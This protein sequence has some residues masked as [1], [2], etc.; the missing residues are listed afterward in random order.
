MTVLVAD[1]IVD[2]VLDRYAL[3]IGDSLTDYRNHLYRGMNYQLRL[4]GMTQAPPEIALAWAT[5]DIGIW[6][7]GTW[8]YLDPSVALAEQLAPEFGI[9]DVARTKAMVADHHKLRAADDLWVEMF[10]L[11]DRVDA[12]RGLYA[13]TGLERSDVREVV[14]ALPYG[15]FHGFLLKTAGK[16]T[17]KHPLRPMPMLRW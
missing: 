7:A 16:W 11:G 1:P 9:T 2:A 3:T 8:D 17:L 4:L 15:G 5:H 14:E 12:F 13:W 10:R 6:T